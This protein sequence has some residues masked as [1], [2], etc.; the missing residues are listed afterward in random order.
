MQMY[1]YVILELINNFYIE[2][3]ILH[4]LIEYFNFKFKKKT[5]LNEVKQ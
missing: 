5:V 2:L 3:Y 4:P 1:E